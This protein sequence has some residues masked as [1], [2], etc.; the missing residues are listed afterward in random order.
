MSA[1]RDPI[2][3]LSP[4]DNVV[5]ARRDIPAGTNLPSEGIVTR[6]LIPAGY[7][8]AVRAIGQGDPVLKYNTVIGYAS[9]N[10]Q[11]GDMMH[12]HNISIDNVDKDYA[13]SRDY[14]PT[15][16]VPEDQ[17][18]TFMGFVRPDGQVGTR[19]Y[20]GVFT[21]SNCAATAARKIANYFT[22]ER[23]RDYPNVDGVVPFIIDGG[24]GL[25]YGGPLELLRRTIGGYLKSPNLAGAVVCALGC[26]RNNIDGMFE[27]LGLQESDMLTRLVLQEIG[28]TRKTVERGIADV[29]R[30]LPVANQF[31]RTPVAADKLTVALQCGGSD[32]FSGL[33]ANPALGAA[34]DKLI[35]CGGTAVLSETTE[36]FGVE[37]T[38][39]RRAVTS[40]V[41]QKLVDRINWWL[42]YSAGSDVQINGKVSPGNNKGGIANIL[43]KSL[44]G[45]K[46]GGETGLMDVIEYAMPITAKGL[47]F[48]DSPGFDPV[49]ATGQVAGGA[50]LIAFTTGRGSCYGGVPVPCT[51]LATNTPMY[52]LMEEDMD[53]NCGLIIDGEKTVQEMGDLI[54]DT[55]LRVASGEKTKSELLGVGEDEFQPWNIG[56]IS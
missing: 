42:Q 17:R 50:N 33:S 21:A 25:P 18:P 29:E 20:I 3:R 10:I 2:I 54:F 4:R 12:S 14:V 1:A 13:F 35:R 34:M 30:M 39:T 32:G 55:L 19:N 6:D 41:G 47:V 53:I 48:M 51:K 9:A 22:P 27:A 37:H 38:L 11:P 44:G 15:Q 45:A 26:E 24:C 16:Y 43:E 8:V 56:I 46:K 28:G 36:I 23:L 40:E 31:V 7:K 5:V 52:Q 49:A